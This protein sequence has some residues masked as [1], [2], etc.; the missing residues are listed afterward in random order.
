MIPIDYESIFRD[1]T[2]IITGVG[3]SG[4]TILGK[5]IGSMTPTVYLFEPAIMKYL[6]NEGNHDAFLGTLF[7]DYLLPIVQGR[8][9]NYCESDDSCIQHHWSDKQV[10]QSRKLRTRKEAVEW[11][12]ESGIKFV[13]KTNELSGDSDLK[14]VFPGHKL[15]HI[16]RNGNDVIHSALA[17]G[18]YTDE[19]LK[20]ACIDRVERHELDPKFFVPWFLDE[21]TLYWPAYNQ[22]TRIAHVWRNLVEGQTDCMV[23]TYEHLIEEPEKTISWIPGY[24]DLVQTDLTE[25]HIASIRNQGR[26]DY[27]SL[28]DR[29]QEPERSKYVATMERLGYKA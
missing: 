6:L 10:N 1:R 27:P 18:W 9:L 17:K 20:N 26:K 25:K 14:S 19:Y 5:L 3:R 21:L 7:E 11:V 15:I 12:N 4:T 28:L 8:S 24:L 2:I 22:E 29:I 16:I 23:L 13:I